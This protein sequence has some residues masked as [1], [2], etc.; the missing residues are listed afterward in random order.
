M[1]NNGSL[2]SNI[3][4][5]KVSSLSFSMNSTQRCEFLTGV[6]TILLL[7]GGLLGSLTVNWVQEGLDNRVKDSINLRLDF[8]FICFWDLR[9]DAGF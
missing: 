2:N 9:A 6:G 8:S 1:S 4:N 7:N 5:P 3:E